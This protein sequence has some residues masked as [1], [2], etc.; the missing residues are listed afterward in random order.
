MM[1][2]RRENN[3]GQ[4]HAQSLLLQGSLSLVCL[5]GLWNGL[6]I[7]FLSPRHYPPM[8]QARFNLPYNS[9]VAWIGSVLPEGPVVLQDVF[10]ELQR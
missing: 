7:V 6:G 5:M 9:R 10:H 3:F 2:A 8:P 1:K 4:W